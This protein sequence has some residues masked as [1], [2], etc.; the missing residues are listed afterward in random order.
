MRSAWSSRQQ[1]GQLPIVQNLSDDL[2][3]FGKR[4]EHVRRCGPALGFS[5]F[6]LGWQVQFFKKD[7]A[8]LL[9]RVDIEGV[10]G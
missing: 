5:C 9:G 2:V 1:S 8:E 7:F 4:F 6:G 3:S 10:A